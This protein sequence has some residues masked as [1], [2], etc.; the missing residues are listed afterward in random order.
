MITDQ[1]AVTIMQ[2]KIFKLRYFGLKKLQAAM[3]ATMLVVIN[4]IGGSVAQAAGEKGALPT[5]EWSFSGP[6]GSFDQ[7]QLQRGYQ[8]YSQVCASCHALEYLH[9]RNLTALGYTDD[10]IKG[11]AAAVEV[12]SGV[13]EYGDPISKPALPSSRFARPYPNRQAALAANGGAYPPDLSMLAKARTGGADYIYAV[14]V[15]YLD[16]VPDEKASQLQM[17]AGQYYNDYYPG[18]VIAMPPPLMEDL[19]AY[20]DGT[21]PTIAQMARDVSAFLTWAADPR[22]EQRRRIGV[23]M[24]LFLIFMTAVFYAAKRRIWAD[25]S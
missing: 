6:F 21:V 14:L 24:I 9:Y 8:I 13:D 7:Q 2:T 12:P 23:K 10:H 25:V 5:Q 4:F 11:I 15:G 19:I 20:Q 1:K 16:E 18:H 3:F 17:G 22:L